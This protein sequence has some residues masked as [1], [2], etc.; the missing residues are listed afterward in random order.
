MSV[1]AGADLRRALLLRVNGP[2]RAG[3]RG[4]CSSVGDECP[5]AAPAAALAAADALFGEPRLLAEPLLL[6]L[7]RLL[8][9][10]GREV[11]SEGV[12]LAPP[13]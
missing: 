6:L 9:S 2:L 7:S 5:D 8:R 12:E 10:L 11:R 13:G 4:A 1:V 3:D